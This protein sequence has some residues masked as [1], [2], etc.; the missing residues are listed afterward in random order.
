MG[1]KGTLLD[2]RRGQRC[3]LGLGLLGIAARRTRL[4]RTVVPARRREEPAA[5][6]VLSGTG[7]TSRQGGPVHRPRRCTLASTS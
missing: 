4:W 1:A 5:V 2:D 6:V 7:A 3:S